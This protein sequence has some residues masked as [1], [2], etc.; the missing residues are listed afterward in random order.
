[1]VLSQRFAL[2]LSGGGGNR[3]RVRGRTEQNVYERSPCFVSPAER[4]TDDL[5]TGQPS[6]GVAPQAIGSPSVPSPIVGAGS[7]ASGRTL[8]GVA[9]PSFD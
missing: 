4:F 5:P 6:F 8:V 7:R 1:M 2:F 3:T 9:L